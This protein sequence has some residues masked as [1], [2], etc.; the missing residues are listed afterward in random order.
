MVAPGVGG[1]SET[2][3]GG[4]VAASTINAGLK[5]GLNVGALVA[6]GCDSTSS[7]WGD[8]QCLAPGSHVAIRVLSCFS[9]AESMSLGLMPLP[10]EP[11][12]SFLII[13]PFFQVKINCH[14]CQPTRTTTISTCSE[15]N[16]VC[17]VR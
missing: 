1:E 13:I 15:R 7:S 2:A 14:V 3:M 17:I 10:V 4:F 11:N 9:A 8:V 6:T 12:L 16:D 5:E